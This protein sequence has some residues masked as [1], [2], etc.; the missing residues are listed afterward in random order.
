MILFATSS[1]SHLINKDLINKTPIK[2]G[3]CTV[4][5]FSDGE[6]YVSI[7]ESPENIQKKEFWVLTGTQPPAEN[8]LELFF[9][10]NALERMGAQKINILFTYFGYARQAIA[11]PGQA[12]SVQVICDIIKNL[13]TSGLINKIYMIHAHSAPIINEYLPFTN[14][15]DLNFFCNKANLYDIIAAP[16]KGA[17]EFAQQVAHECN[18][19][20]IVLEKTRPEQE[21]VKIDPSAQLGTSRTILNKKILIVDDII[22]TG[23]TLIESAAM[24]KKMGAL[25][26]SAA[27]THGV[28]SPGSR[29]RLEESELDKI[30]VTDTIAQPKS[31]GKI[32]ATDIASFVLGIILQQVLDVKIKSKT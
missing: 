17:F 18:K 8:L 9:L 27:V 30:Y 1:A 25:S 20:V 22:S 23:R 10:L 4:K 29:Q 5:Q 6:L 14:V 28:F 13:R 15:I 3:D 21:H 16:D 26:V 31:I 12:C 2:L 19:E 11:A 24:L 32:E 7:N